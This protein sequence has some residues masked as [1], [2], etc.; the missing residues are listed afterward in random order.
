MMNNLTVQGEG[1]V[2]CRSRFYSANDV[3]SNSIFAFSPG[4]NWL[5]GEIDSG[6]WAVSYLLSVYN[7]YP[8]DF[9]LLKDP[10]LSIDDRSVSLDEVF[11]LSCYM[12]EVYPLFSSSSTVENLLLKG[13]KKRGSDYS[14][15]DIREMFCID[16]NRFKQ[17]IQCAGNEAFKAMA[18]VGFAVGKEIYC[19]PWLSQK[20]FDGF[21]L[22]L[23]FLLELLDK[24]NKTVIFPIGM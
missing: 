11:K 12:D 8:K 5:T 4:I 18:A 23:T 10:V 2:Y 1:Y 13:L 15:S 17:S 22:H 19:F 3:L 20:R 21:H 7:R 14:C 16:S 24:L 9:V 6:N